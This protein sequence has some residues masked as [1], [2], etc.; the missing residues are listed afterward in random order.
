MEKPPPADPAVTSPLSREMAAALHALDLQFRVGLR[1]RLADISVP[2]S[3]KACAALH[4]LVGAAGM[5]GHAALG[6]FARDAMDA[7]SASPQQLDRHEA[8]MAGVA[9]EIS[10]LKA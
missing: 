9:A 4:C 5:Y 8:A 1:R 10:R 2:E 7:L 6:G 3:T